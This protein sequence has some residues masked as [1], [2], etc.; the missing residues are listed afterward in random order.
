MVMPVAAVKFTVTIPLEKLHPVI[1]GVVILNNGVLAGN[2][3]VIAE[4]KDGRFVS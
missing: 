4:P 3:R 1:T 2:F